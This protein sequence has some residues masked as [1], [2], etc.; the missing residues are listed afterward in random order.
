MFV[1]RGAAAV[2]SDEELTDLAGAAVRGLVRSTQAEYPDRVVLVDDDA[3]RHSSAG[4]LAA[5]ASTAPEAEIA[6]RQDAIWVPRAMRVPGRPDGDPE[7]PT[8]VWDSTGTVLITGGTGGVGR[9]IARHLV[10]R[11]GVRHLL[12]AGRRGG[13]APEPPS[14]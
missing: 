11:H 9:E 3:A 12:L 5:A 14:W 1:T 10:T 2:G 6:L 8:T 13:A 4:V 7:A